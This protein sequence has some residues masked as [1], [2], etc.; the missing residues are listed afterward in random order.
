M[1]QS[2]L[3]ANLGMKPSTQAKRLW[4]KGA[5]FALLAANLKSK[6]IM[7]KEQFR[8][9]GPEAAIKNIVDRLAAAGHIAKPGEQMDSAKDAVALII[10]LLVGSAT[11][12]TKEE[13]QWLA[14]FLQND[15]LGL[16]NNS[17]FRQAGAKK[18]WWAKP[19]E[20]ADAQPIAALTS[21][22]D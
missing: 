7:T 9:L 14:A 22:L 8:S 3:C 16:L 17:Q 18:G 6:I 10:A 11:S 5:Q 1:R 2:Y 20:K 13:V 19:I 15:K 4:V 12:A 21:L